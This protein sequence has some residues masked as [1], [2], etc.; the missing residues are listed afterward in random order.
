MMHQV[1][2]ITAPYFTWKTHSVDRQAA[3]SLTIPESAP[4]IPNPIHRWPHNLVRMPKN[5]RKD[6]RFDKGHIGPQ[7]DVGGNCR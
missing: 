4:H 6:G 2:T 7:Q 5:V 3:V 1:R